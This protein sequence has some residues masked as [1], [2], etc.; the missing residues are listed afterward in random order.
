MW[1]NSAADVKPTTVVIPPT[2][3]SCLVFYVSLCETCILNIPKLNHTYTSTT[4]HNNT[5]NVTK[6]YVVHSWQ[7]R[8]LN[9][10]LKERTLTFLKE[11]TDND[12]KDYWGIDIRECPE[13]VDDKVIYRTQIIDKNQNN[14]I[15]QI[16]SNVGIRPKEHAPVKEQKVC[17]AG[18][19]GSPH[20][21]V[22]CETVL[23]PS[24]KHCEEHRICE[25]GKCSCAWGYTGERCNTECENEKWGRSCEEL[26]QSGCGTCDKVTGICWTDYPQAQASIRVNDIWEVNIIALIA[27]ILLI[28]MNLCAF[29]AFV[30]NCKKCCQINNNY[31]QTDTMEETRLMPIPSEESQAIEEDIKIEFLESY[32]KETMVLS[33]KIE[34][35]FCSFEATP[36]KSCAVGLQSK[37]INKNKDK[38]YIPYDCTRVILQPLA[39][40]GT[41]DYINAT[42][43][44]GYDRPKTYISCQGPKFY[45]IKDFWRL[46]WQEEIETIVMAT[47]FIE[48]K[49]RMCAEYW[50]QRLN[51]LFEYGEMTI[52]LI[53][54][55]NYEHHDIRI[56]EIYYMQHC[57]RIKHL[58]LRWDS[59]TTLYPNVVVPVVKYIRQI[60]ENSVVP[61]LIHS[62]FG[63]NRTGTLI[64]CDLALAMASAENKVNFYALMKNLR[65]QRPYMVNKMEH[66]LLAHLIVLECLMES[67]TPFKKSLA[68][69]FDTNIIEQQLSYLKRFSWH[70]ETVKS[71]DLEPPTSYNKLP[72][73]TYVDG[74]KRNK[75]Y[76]IMQQPKKE[77]ASRFWKMVVENK[78]SRILFLNKL[79][80]KQFLWPK[81]CKTSSE[82]VIVR[83][84]EEVTT[85]YVTK[86]RLLL[87]AY[88]KGSG[89]ILYQNFVEVFEFT[90]WNE[91]Q[92]LPNSNN[93]FFQIIK[94]FNFAKNRTHLVACR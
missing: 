65:E 85:G 76:L 60:A 50:P 86:T 49:T 79:R 28:L 42:Y 51:T 89:V 3:K 88:K 87:Q 93:N 27:I 29:V 11:K 39:G 94:Q 12:A 68:E 92:Q 37:N 38:N 66:Y 24:H 48:Y 52:Q 44:N 63:V 16:M 61:I 47:N 71:W 17:E 84:L 82:V 59:E 72:T 35:Q 73:P 14:H 43:I 55:E 4:Q 41:D 56:F 45:T 8:R 57:R 21:D 54:Q 40:M 33:K 30:N 10:E 31:N 32:L 91:K 26:C 5:T 58:H 67:E 1:S 25:N 20:C 6:E 7:S 69:N 62:G 83:Y 81:R 36:T 15:C 78:I 75:K 64:L 23:G 53:K 2:E 34:S 80:E 77:M 19:L 70:D 18:K 9:L 46:I 90:D 13:T 22:S 74:Y